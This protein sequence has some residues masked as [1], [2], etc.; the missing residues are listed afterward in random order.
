MDDRCLN[1]GALLIAGQNFCRSCGA[2]AASP[3]GDAPTRILADVPTAHAPNTTALPPRATGEWALSARP[4]EQ[5]TPFGGGGHTAPLNVSAPLGQPRGTRLM[6]TPALL[7]LLLILGLGAALTVALISRGIFVNKILPG[8]DRAETA[9]DASAPR[10]DESVLSED[11]ATVSGRE[12]VVTK[13]F[14]V[15][16]DTVF[17]F[18]STSGDVVV[19]GWDK[20]SVEVR[21]TK[22]GGTAEERRGAPVTLRRGD[23]TFA[24][25]APDSTVKVSFEV[26]LPRGAREV[27][28]SSGDG[29]VEASRLEAPLN[30]SVRNG[31]ISL[32]D[33]RGPVQAKS[34]NGNIDVSYTGAG[35]EGEH[36]FATVNGSVNV[37]LADGMK[38]DVKGSV[39]NGRI[40]V[41]EGLPLQPQKRQVGWQLD[42]PLGGGGPLLSM[43]TVNGSIKVIK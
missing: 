7:G 17:S 22:R 16:P 12:T 4:T 26:K 11:G 9:R 25:A 15:E 40:E 30:I 35:R 13:T 24:L 2:R 14:G 34:V 28:L 43:K 29:K 20:E 6:P 36:E 37:R 19:E 18:K 32:E 42:A 1:C 33:V 5:Q 31:S 27:K 38:A 8:G 3:E 10:S 39:V 23:E 21:V 41:G